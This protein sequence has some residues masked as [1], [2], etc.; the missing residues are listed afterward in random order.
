LHLARKLILAQRLSITLRKDDKNSTARQLT[1]K[2]H[3]NKKA[4]INFTL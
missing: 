3:A 1:G 4:V 2:L